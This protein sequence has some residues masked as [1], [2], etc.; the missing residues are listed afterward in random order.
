MQTTPAEIGPTSPRH[1]LRKLDRRTR[2]GRFL[3]RTE[4]ALLDHASRGGAEPVS[5]P[6][7]ILIGRVA[8]DLL[9][10][11]MLD[12]KML[13]GTASDHDLRIGHALRNSV[14]LALRDLGLDAPPARG[15]TLDEIAAE[16]GRSRPARS[17]RPRRASASASPGPRN[18]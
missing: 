17:S 1:R 9:R 16:P 4:A 8:A 14:R 18:A 15:P 6:K 10:L 3:D 12:R 7:R 11:E 2:E 5:M 13:D